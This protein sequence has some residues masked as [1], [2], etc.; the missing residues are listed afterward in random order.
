MSILIFGRS[1]TMGLFRK[2]PIQ[3][4][5]QSHGARNRELLKLILSKG[6]DP[7]VLRDIDLHFWAFGAEAAGELSTALKAQGYTLVSTKPAATDPSLWN[8]E[9]KIVASPLS[10]TASAFVETLVQLAAAHKGEYDGWGTS[11]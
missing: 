4:A 1:Q 10:V 3:K 9:T 7:A 11:I 8:V 5:L 2:S 6:V